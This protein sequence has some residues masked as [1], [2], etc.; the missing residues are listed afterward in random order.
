MQGLIEISSFCISHLVFPFL[1]SINGRSRRN[2]MPGVINFGL[3]S[4][5]GSSRCS[6]R[7]YNSNFAKNRHAS[8]ATGARQPA[9]AAAAA[10]KNPIAP[11]FASRK[12][13]SRSSWCPAFP[14]PPSATA[15]AAAAVAVPPSAA[16]LASLLTPVQSPLAPTTDSSSSY[17]LRALN[18][19]APGKSGG[20]IHVRTR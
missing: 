1:F 16:H 9:A 18:V 20:G 7:S 5:R 2:A 3:I 15:A 11:V 17:V 4:A 14:P 13:Q 19:A 10:D 8:C 12:G 6:S